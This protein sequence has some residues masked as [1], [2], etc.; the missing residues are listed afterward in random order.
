MFVRACRF[1]L[2]VIVRRCSS[3]I[4]LMHSF[5]VI[6][7]HRFVVPSV[8]DRFFV[9]SGQTPS[10]IL[11]RLHH[12]CD[13]SV[14][15]T[16]W[17]RTLAARTSEGCTFKSWLNHAVW[18][19]TLVVLCLF[20]FVLL[21]HAPICI[22]HSLVLAVRTLLLSWNAFKTNVQF[23]LMCRMSYGGGQLGVR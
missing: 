15:R 1:M 2:P 14:W 8:P 11:G 9:Q 7:H 19:Q 17:Q 3:S 20:F 10:F 6:Q 21:L 13:N 12:A 18:G 4:A 5:S 16:V 22:W 23:S